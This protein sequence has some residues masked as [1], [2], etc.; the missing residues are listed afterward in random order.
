MPPCEGR[1]CLRSVSENIHS[2]APFA[3]LTRWLETQQQPEEGIEEAVLWLLVDRL[4]DA[5]GPE[6]FVQRA[7]QITTKLSLTLHHRHVQVGQPVSR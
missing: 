5:A 7:Q 2:T 6:V 4:G 3:L 1:G